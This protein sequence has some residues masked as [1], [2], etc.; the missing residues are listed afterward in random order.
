MIDDLIEVATA[1]DLSHPK[2]P[3]S[4]KPLAS[5]S[6]KAEVLCSTMRAGVVRCSRR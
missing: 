2:P 5:S 4:S 1:L 6:V 3:G